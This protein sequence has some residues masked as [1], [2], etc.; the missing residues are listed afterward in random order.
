[1][2]NKEE[3]RRYAR[4]LN[5][6]NFGVE[7]QLKLKNAKVLVIGAGG[8]GSPLLQY[9]AAAGV[10]HIGIVEF[11]VVDESNLQRQI[12]YKTSDL[13]KPKALAA[14]KRL[15]ELNPLIHIE[16]FQETFSRDNALELIKGFDIVA[17][18]TDNFPTRYLVNDACVLAGKPNV[19]ASIFRY[20]GQVSVFNLSLEDGSYSPNYR[21]LYPKPPPPDMVP[22]CAEGGVLGV[23]PGIIGS[24]Q[25]NEVIKIITGLGKPLS[26]RLCLFDTADF[27]MRVIKYS[28]QPK[29][30][31]TELID[32]ETFCSGTP[33]K[34]K[35]SM[36]RNIDPKSLN[37]LINTCEEVTLVDVRED[38]ERA[39]YNIGGLHIRLNDIPASVDQIP[40]E[41]KVIIYCRSGVRSANAIQFLQQ[42]HGY[43][44]LFN[45]IGGMIAWDSDIK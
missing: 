32:Y 14:K 7:A 41:G 33:K 3:L 25:A 27:S 40:K 19:Y 4:H 44:N 23:L 17:D 43:N 24:M 38:H 8:L 39:A 2:L 45:L 26:G 20:E 5:L 42:N 10:G 12:L 16:V 31:I 6:P 28:K 9:L 36:V 11:D 21:D 1:M 37:E 13:G 30:I 22:N 18:G 15:E 29:N 35:S 34:D